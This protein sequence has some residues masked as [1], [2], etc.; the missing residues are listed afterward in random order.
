MK[1]FYFYKLKQVAAYITFAANLAA[2]EGSVLAVTGA[3][4]FQWMKICN[5][6]TRFCN[7]IGGALICGFVASLL[8]AVISS[9]SAFILFRLYSPKRFLLFKGT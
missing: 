8:M 4:E 3:K 9:I 2:L 6:F 1:I 5:R 7:Q